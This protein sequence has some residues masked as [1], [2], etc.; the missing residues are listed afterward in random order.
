MRGLNKVILIGNLG[1]KPEMKHDGEMKRASF[2]LATTESYKSKTGER[3][4]V[5]EWHNIVVWG[6]LAEIAEK[7]LDKGMPIYL[8]GKIKTRSWDDE[9][10]VKKYITEIRG[11]N[12]IM[13]GGKRDSENQDS[14]ISN[15]TNTDTSVSI[16]ATQP[17][18]DL[19]F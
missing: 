17:D 2:S 6:T 5:T 10:G 7:Y 12:F 19:P 18:D 16:P 4:D 14:S 3:V 8:E 9:H 1:K 15:T 11:D 13:L